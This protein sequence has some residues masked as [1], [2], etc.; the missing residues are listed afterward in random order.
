M[1]QAGQHY[2]GEKTAQTIV[3]SLGQGDIKSNYDI[4]PLYAVNDF[5]ELMC[6]DDNKSPLCIVTKMSSDIHYQCIKAALDSIAIK[7]PCDQH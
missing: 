1:N 3:D 7:C 5:Q 6:K 2:L 4:V